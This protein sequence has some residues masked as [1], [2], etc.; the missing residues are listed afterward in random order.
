MTDFICDYIVP[1]TFTA[2]SGWMLANVL[3]LQYGTRIFYRDE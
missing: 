1:L 2:A 3:F